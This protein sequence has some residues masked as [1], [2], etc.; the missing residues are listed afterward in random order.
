MIIEYMLK[1]FQ[2]GPEDLSGFLLL[3]AEELK[4]VMDG[5][6]GLPEKEWS[7]LTE[8]SRKFESVVADEGARVDMITELDC[9]QQEQK[10]SVGV[11]AGIVGVSR[12]ALTSWLDLS[13]VPS[14]G[15][16]ASIL[17]LLI[18][19]KHHGVE[20][21]RHSPVIARFSVLRNA[22]GVPRRVVGESLGV[23]VQTVANWEARRNTPPN[24]LIN[25]LTLINKSFESCLYALNS[26]KNKVESEE[27]VEV[28]VVEE[29]PSTAFSASKGVIPTKT[30]STVVRR[31]KKNKVKLQVWSANKKKGADNG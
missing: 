15:S 20:T 21:V 10:W 8:L 11:T 19:V 31:S 14:Y 28:E 13:A 23:T 5:D 17:A 25:Q 7:K 16:T 30:P 18:N 3:S 22:L 29:K 12:K 4:K 2:W 1:R 9:L 26:I 6:A 27:V 24:S